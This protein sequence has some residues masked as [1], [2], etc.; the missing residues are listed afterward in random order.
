M[1]FFFFFCM[2][3]TDIL[4]NFKLKGNK[5]PANNKNQLEV[6]LKNTQSNT[7]AITELFV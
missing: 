2:T 6:L 7:P 3:K 5:K 4:C 1:S